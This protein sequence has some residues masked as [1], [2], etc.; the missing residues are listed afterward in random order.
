[1]ISI[2]CILIIAGIFFGDLK[3]KNLIEQNGEKGRNERRES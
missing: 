3:I 1:M 2:C